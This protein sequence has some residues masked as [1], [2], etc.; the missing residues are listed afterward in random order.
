M[1]F[2]GYIVKV[3]A[4]TLHHHSRTL[5]VARLATTC[6]SLAVSF[7]MRT[8]NASQHLILQGI[9]I[10]TQAHEQFRSRTFCFLN[11]RQ[12]DVFRADVIMRKTLRLLYGCF[13][14]PLGPRSIIGIIRWIIRLTGHHRFDFLHDGIKG[15][16]DGR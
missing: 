12:Q 2:F 13:H 8:V 9:K 3:T 10:G 16:P 5:A 15:H 6:R 11:Q 7:R 14:D 4:E 1:A